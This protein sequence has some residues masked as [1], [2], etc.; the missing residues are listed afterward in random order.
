MY[1]AAQL[2]RHCPDSSISRIGGDEFA[3][4]VEVEEEIVHVEELDLE[5]RNNT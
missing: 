3:I 2:S 4:I 5:I 1:V